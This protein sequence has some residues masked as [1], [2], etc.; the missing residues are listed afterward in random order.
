MNKKLNKL[1]LFM[2]FVIIFL[3]LF[4]HSSIVKESIYNSSKLWF[5]NLVPSILPIYLFI[6]IAINY[7]FFDYLCN[8]F[9]P[10]LK[11]LFNI[12]KN[13]SYIF[14]L[15]ILSG[16]PSN[17]K[18][19]KNALDDNIIDI[20]EANRLLI[21]T[22]FSNP[23]FIIEGIGVNFLNNKCIGI[24]ILISHY[25]G[26][27][28]L[29]IINRNNYINMIDN[30]NLN[31]KNK[32]NFIN[33]LSNSI[34]NTFSILILLYGIITFFMIITSLININIHINQ[35]LNSIFCGLLEITNGINLLSKL[36]IPILHKGI[37]ITF[38]L[39]FGGFC[40]HLQVFSILKEYSLKYS[41]YLKNRII[42]GII[43]SCIFYVVYALITK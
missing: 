17:S 28:I 23:L 26:N 29:G 22:H 40:I 37:I 27:I 4:S 5:Y 34:S 10:V 8:I 9:Y 32:K 35:F 19:L 2:F 21:F 14:I 24:I 30:N 43:S 7:N 16:F 42:H 11:K 25:L 33:T 3:E 1:L 12:K 41:T 6:D 36:S 13:I 18:Y 15:S 38:L 20:M 31:N 39:S